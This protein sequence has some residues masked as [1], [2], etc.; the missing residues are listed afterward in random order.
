MLNRHRFR[1]RLYA[2]LALVAATCASGPAV[3]QAHVKWFSDFSFAD[4]PLTLA[5]A[6]TP[7]V[8]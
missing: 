1:Y 6:I 5:E 3:A 7:T 2:A 8:L 4:Q